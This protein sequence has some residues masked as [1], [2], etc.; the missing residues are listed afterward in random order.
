[1]NILTEKTESLEYLNDSIK[2]IEL[3]DKATQTE[4]RTFACNNESLILFDLDRIQIDSNNE[5]LECLSLLD[6]SFDS[7]LES[8]PIHS[9]NPEYS[10]VI[11][12]NDIG[13][14]MDFTPPATLFQPNAF[15]QCEMVPIE[16]D[17]FYDFSFHDFLNNISFN[18]L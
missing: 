6:V 5:N 9:P 10:S 18:E 7:P 15:D 8:T 14:L 13:S 11:F 12:Q 4:T 2:A 16:N 3:A 1:M 17:I